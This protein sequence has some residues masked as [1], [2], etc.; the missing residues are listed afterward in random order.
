MPLK[1]HMQKIH[2]HR[3][4]GMHHF[5]LSLSLDP[6]STIWTSLCQCFWISVYKPRNY[7][8][9]LFQWFYSLY[10]HHQ[11]NIMHARHYWPLHENIQYG[12]LHSQHYNF[13][14]Q[15]SNHVLS[16]AI[17]Q[18]YTAFF[19]SNSAHQLWNLPEEILFGLFV[20]TLND[21][22]ERE[23]AQKDEGY[24]SRGESLSIPTPFRKAPQ[25]YHISTGE[26]LSFNPTTPLTT[27]KQHPVHSP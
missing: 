4:K 5:L 9:S 13:G 25:I 15:I 1:K 17:E 23:L 11:V 16:N 18:V 6:S 27:A 3:L 26:H 20:T 14:S 7:E 24:E 2:A 12:M 19:Y 22:F 21:T 10:I 8:L